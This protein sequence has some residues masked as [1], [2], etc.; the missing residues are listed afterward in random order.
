MDTRLTPE[1]E[2]M[3]DIQSRIQSYTTEINQKFQGKT[4]VTITHKDSVVFMHKTFKD[5]DYLTKKH[6]HNPINGQ[7]AVR[8]RDNDRNIEMDLHKPYIDSYRFKK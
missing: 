5:F 3:N 1:G 7:I 4:I 6:E 8:Y 2:C